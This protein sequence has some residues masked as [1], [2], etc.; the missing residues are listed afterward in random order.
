VVGWQRGH[1]DGHC[2]ACNRDRGLFDVVVSERNWVTVGMEGEVE[3]GR[4]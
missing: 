4:A 2:G 3:E 1:R